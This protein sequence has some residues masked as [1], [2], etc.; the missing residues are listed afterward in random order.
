[1]AGLA[2]T[3]H[4]IHCRCFVRRGLASR[5]LLCRRGRATESAGRKCTYRRQDLEVAT[6][7]SDERVRSEGEGRELRLYRYD[8]EASSI[9]SGYGRDS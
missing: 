5:S 1:M 7:A 9:S 3:G 8:R 4:L 6:W 2:L